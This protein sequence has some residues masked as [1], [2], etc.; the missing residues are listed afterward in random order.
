MYVCIHISTH[1]YRDIHTV[2]YTYIAQV[3]HFY[4]GMKITTLPYG[5]QLYHHAAT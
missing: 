3:I 2:T 5:L 4:A 1:M